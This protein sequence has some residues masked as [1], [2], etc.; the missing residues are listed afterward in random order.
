M[1]LYNPYDLIII[2]E[3]VSSSQKILRI[4]MLLT[5]NNKEDISQAT[6]P[7]IVMIREK[8]Q[9]QQN[10]EESQYFMV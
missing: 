3:N 5:T 6:V 2:Q 8:I 9:D 4:L 7:L 10:L 1:M